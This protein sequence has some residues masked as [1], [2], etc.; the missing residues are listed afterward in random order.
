M[1]E[2]TDIL[3][4]IADE[5]STG[6]DVMLTS[7][8]AATLWYGYQELRRQNEGVGRFLGGLECGAIVRSNMVEETQESA[9]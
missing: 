1:S 7:A 5:I 2:L 8:E 9:A 4:Y 6:H 3:A